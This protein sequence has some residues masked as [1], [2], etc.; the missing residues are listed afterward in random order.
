MF[1]TEVNTAVESIS[2]LPEEIRKRFAESTEQFIS[3]TILPWGEHC[4]ECVWPVCYTT[5]E[6][7][8][9]RKDGSC[10]QFVGG[11]V[12]LDHETG[13]SPYL[14]KL[15]FKRWAKL[16]TVGTIELHQMQDAA[17]KE[18]QDVF[19]GGLGQ[20][21][22]L[23]GAL[24]TKVLRKI[25]YVRRRIA[26]EAPTSD[27][28]PDNFLLECYNPN[29]RRI[30]LTFTIKARSGDARRPFQHM[31]ILEPGYTRATV[32]VPTILQVV[33]L[34]Q[35][36]EVEI[37]PNECDGTVLYFGLMDFVKERQKKLVAV[38]ATNS[39]HKCKCVVWDLDNTL[40]DGTLVEDGAEKIRLRQGVVEVIK[41]LDRRGILNSIASKNNHEDA[42][43]VLKMCGLD[44]YFL[45]PQISWQPKSQS[46]AQ[47]AQLLNIGIDTLM[48]VDD[49]PFEREEV[50]AGVPQVRTFEAAEYLRLPEMEAFRVPVTE[51]SRTRRVMYQQQQQRTAKQEV[52]NG[53][54]L[55][56]LKDCQ[57]ELEICPLE[58]R[59]LKR[60][61]EL[62]QRTNQLN[63]SGNRYP[64]AKLKEIM[65]SDFLETYVISAQDRFGKYGTVGFAVV[66]KREPR[67]LDL[68][69]SCRIQSKRV[70]HAVL[71]FMLERFDH[72]DFHAN[73]LKTQKNAPGGKVFDEVGF[74]CG[75]E[76]DGLRSLVFK[77]GQK[78]PHDGIITIKELLA[79]K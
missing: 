26:E 65:E 2:K 46:I 30:A 37:V 48:F 61:Y 67:L 13:L 78:I 59:N 4:T 66:D 22:P 70:E 72:R 39:N 47:I 7:Y 54:Y 75:E 36:F 23:P 18:R 6:L 43:K 10:R 76:K 41:E 31:I 56:F 12:R 50:K 16:W 5:C 73:Y 3:R 49:Q 74:E 63:F 33:D 42:M 9:P 77:S 34:R 1:E 52:F 51:E 40:W 19:I 28:L 21:V 15:K 17:K 35:P 71:C 69:F 68:M 11:V 60:V 27:E 79:A 64:Q 32:S 53:D 57:M 45:Y 14:Q 38:P 20:A 58:E 44:D 8:D 29:S 24:K 25:N 62:A 55:G